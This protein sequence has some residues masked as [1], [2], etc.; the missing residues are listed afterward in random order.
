M[1]WD[2]E[3]EPLRQGG[4]APSAS[5]AAGTVRTINVTFA[6]EFPT[7]PVMEAV[8]KIASSTARVR[9]WIGG[10]STTGATIFALRE[11]NTGALDIHWRA[12]E[13]TQ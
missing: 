11:D 6:Q 12:T 9:V 10:V 13:P 3:R 4:I 8:V 5:V 1:G 7:I 2:G